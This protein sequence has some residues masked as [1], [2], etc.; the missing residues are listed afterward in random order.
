MALSDDLRERVV[1]AVVAGG[2]SRNA[3]AKRLGVSIASAVRRVARFKE[4]ARFPRL[5]G[6]GIAVPV[7]SRSI[8]IICS[9]SFADSRT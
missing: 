4:R 7:A 5:R 1:G 8:A 3:A 9:A 6:A 2:M